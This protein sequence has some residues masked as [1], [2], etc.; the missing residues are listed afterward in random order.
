MYAVTNREPQSLPLK[1]DHGMKPVMHKHYYSVLY[2]CIF[3]K[4]FRGSSSEIGHSS[5]S[6]TGI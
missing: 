2:P 1:E 6:I 4:L 5:L 3:T